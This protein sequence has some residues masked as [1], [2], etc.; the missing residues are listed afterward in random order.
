MPNRLWIAAVVAV[1]PITAMS[2]PAIQAAKAATNTIPIVMAF[3]SIDPIRSADVRVM[4]RTSVRSR[5][6]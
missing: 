5:V 4:T 6:P 2:P 1:T 3:T